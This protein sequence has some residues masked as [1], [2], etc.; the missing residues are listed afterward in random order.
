MLD[1]VPF[2]IPIGHDRL[3]V[4]RLPFATF[5]IIALNIAV[6]AT[7]CSTMERDSKRESRRFS[8]LIGFYEAHPWIELPEEVVA[9]LGDSE[10]RRY[11]QH[12]KWIAWYA[13]APE[14]VESFL[15]S[16]PLAD[17]PELPASED[18]EL[19]KTAF[20]SRV[21]DLEPG[22]GTAHQRRADE[23][24]QRYLAA[25]GAS[26]ARRFGYTPTEPRSRSRG[27][28]RRAFT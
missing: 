27:S 4:G 17:S 26:I 13:A 2:I 28:A 11:E 23:L 19:R 5:G 9:G 12:R 20:L 14:E 15:E 10:Q 8:E 16:S 6:F 1:F 21:A 22:E 7:T 3:T 24:A 18:E 25:R